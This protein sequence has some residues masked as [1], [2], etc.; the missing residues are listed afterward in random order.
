MVYQP[1]FNEDVCEADL[2]VMYNHLSGQQQKQRAHNEIGLEGIAHQS[3]YIFI[4]I[5][6]YTCK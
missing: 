2:I 5:Y 3:R 4:Y 1:T 6:K